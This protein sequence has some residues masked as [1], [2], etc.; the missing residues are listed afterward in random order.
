MSE[1]ITTCH[2][3][4]S[5]RLSFLGR[6]LTRWI[7]LAMALG[8]AQGHLAPTVP[9]PARL[10]SAVTMVATKIFRIDAIGSMSVAETPIRAMTARWPPAL[11]WP[12]DG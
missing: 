1:P 11:A 12:T 10:N 8:V 6:Y 2:P 3:R 7:F 9:G 5:G 4:V